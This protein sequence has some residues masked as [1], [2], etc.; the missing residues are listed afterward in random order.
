VE[1]HWYYTEKGLKRGP[2]SPDQLKHLAAS[3]RLQP[4]DLVWKEGMAEWVGAGGIKGL[5]STVSVTKSPPPLPSPS[6]DTPELETRTCEW[7]SKLIPAKSLACPSCTKWRKDIYRDRHNLWTFLFASCA[8]LIVAT[9]LFVNIYQESASS[10]GG[11]FS[12]NWHSGGFSLDW[13]NQIP[14]DKGP[15]GMP[16]LARYEFS[17]SKFLTSLSGWVVIGFLI[18]SVSSVVAS[19]LFS[20]RLKRKTGTIL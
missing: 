10:A 19:Q 14:G 2:L 20:L 7:C 8:F 5:F 13:H 1:S 9:F 12:K 3:G 15:F 17:V 16:G 4:S 18:L 11:A 6:Q